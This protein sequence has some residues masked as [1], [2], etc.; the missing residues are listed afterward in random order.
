M[1]Q[2][3]QVSS[4]FSNVAGNMNTLTSVTEEYVNT[5]KDSVSVHKA[6]SM[7]LDNEHQSIKDIREKLEAQ[8]QKAH[9]ALD[10][11]V[12]AFVDVAQFVQV[13][14]KERA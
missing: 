10:N 5:I 13:T 1:Q 8:Y 3:A 14:L 9:T 12:R 11:L 7:D 6:K 4:I 2:M